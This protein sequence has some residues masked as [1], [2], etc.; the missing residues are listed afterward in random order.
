MKANFK[1][2]ILWNIYIY[3]KPILGPLKNKNNSFYAKYIMGLIVGEKIALKNKT[4]YIKYTISKQAVFLFY[5]VFKCQA[6]HFKKRCLKWNERWS[7][8]CLF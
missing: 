3:I 1:Q 7:L 6:K 2:N 5:F 4:Y 8:K